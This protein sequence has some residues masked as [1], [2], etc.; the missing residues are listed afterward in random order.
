MEIIKFGTK[1]N[2]CYKFVCEECGCVFVAHAHEYVKY[3]GKMDTRYSTT[4]PYCGN[5]VDDYLPNN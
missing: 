5:D 1:N 3:Q 4:C 2:N